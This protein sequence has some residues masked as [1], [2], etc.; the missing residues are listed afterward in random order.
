MLSEAGS[1]HIKTVPSALVRTSRRLNRRAPGS[2]KD[3]KHA[4]ST[5]GNF[6]RSESLPPPVAVCEPA[7][8]SASL[9]RR[10][11]HLRRACAL[12][13]RSGH[14]CLYL[15]PCFLCSASK[16]RECGWAASSPLGYDCV[17]HKLIINWK[18]VETVREIFRQYLRPGW[19]RDET[20]RYLEREQIRGK[21]RAVKPE[22]TPGA[23]F[24]RGAPLPSLEQPHLPSGKLG[25]TGASP[26][27]ASTKPIS[28]AKHCGIRVSRDP[29]RANNQA[30]RSGKSRSAAQPC[31]AALSL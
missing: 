21:V 28:L 24:S 2:R 22:T 14:L 19:V 8:F 6:P 26:I 16:K 17:D 27:L 10:K 31:S 11:R 20:Q 3:R 9:V 12:C 5:C 30:H 4:F 1:W 13:S 29:L 23:T 18:E 15:F 7:L 25:F